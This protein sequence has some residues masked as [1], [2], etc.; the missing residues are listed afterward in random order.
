MSFPYVIYARGKKVQIFRTMFVFSYVSNR[1]C[2]NLN[3][4]SRVINSWVILFE[5]SPKNS[6]PTYKMVSNGS[7]LFNFQWIRTV[8]CQYWSNSSM[9]TKIASLAKLP[10]RARIHFTEPFTMNA[11]YTTRTVTITLLTTKIKRE[12]QTKRNETKRNEIETDEKY[13]NKCHLLWIRLLKSIA[14]K[15]DID[16][17]LTIFCDRLVNSGLVDTLY[18]DAVFGAWNACTAGGWLF[19]GYTW[20]GDPCIGWKPVKHVCFWYIYIN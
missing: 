5:I 20:Y 3:L 11:I 4:S 16:W 1:G 8:K 9:E 6:L 2:S 14:S 13:R 12:N 10:S 17:L 15:C 18:S 19:I 7:Y